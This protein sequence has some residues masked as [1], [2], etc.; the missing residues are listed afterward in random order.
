MVDANEE[1]DK[2]PARPLTSYERNKQN[3]MKSNIVL[4]TSN[5]SD[6]STEE[7]R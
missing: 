3:N 6:D 4:P 2:P 5:S 1:K 7:S